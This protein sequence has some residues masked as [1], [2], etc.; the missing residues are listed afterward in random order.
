MPFARCL[1]AALADQ[2]LT[3]EEHDH[4]Q[5]VHD[6]H[7]TDY[8]RHMPAQEAAAQAARETFAFIE[9]DAAERRRQTFLS[10][11][12]RA[13]IQE[14]LDGH[15]N[16]M[17][18]KADPY[19][20]AQGL[21]D[22]L[23]PGRKG[24][25]VEQ[26]HEFWRGQAQGHLDGAYTTWKRNMLGQR[27]NL[28]GMA[29]VVRE[30][31]GERTGDEAAMM[32]AAG[33]KKASE[34]LRQA[35]NRFGGHIGHLEDWGLPQNHVADRIR[36]A[37]FEAWHDAMVPLL[38]RSRMVDRGMGRP[39]SDKMLKKAL[40]KTY[41]SILT[42]GWDTRDPTSSRGKAL[43]NK[44]DE[45]RFLHF[46]DADS[47]F[48]YQQK[49]G[50]GD[51]INAMLS[52]IDAMSRDVAHMQVMGPNPTATLA[53]LQQ[54]LVKRAAIDNEPARATKA[55]VNLNKLFVNYT[56]SNAAP[57]RP[58][59]A[60]AIDDIS[61]LLTAAQLGAAT[62]SAVPSDL[63]FQRLTRSFNGLPEIK[64][65]AT[66]LKQMNPAD[67][68]HRLAA[69][70]M[71]L[72]AQHYAQV[73]GQQGRYLG[74]IYGHEWSRWITDRVLGVSGLT[75]WTSAGR[76]AFGVDFYGHVADMRDVQ[77][78]ALRV[79][80]RQMLERYG[81]KQHDWNLIRSTE[82]MDVHGA[83]FISPPDILSRVDLAPDEA[84]DLASKLA[85]AAQT[86]TEFAVPSGSL[87]S[88][89]EIT[90]LDHPGEFVS[91]FKRSAAMYRTFGSTLLLSHGRRMMSLGKQPV[92]AGKYAASAI[93]SSVVAGAIA[94]QMK[95]LIAGRDP[96][97]M[98]GAAFWA[99]AFVTGGGG[100]LMADLVYAGINGQSS[101]GQGVASMVGGPIG[102][103]FGD[104]ANTFLGPGGIGAVG[105]EPGAT[106]KNMPTRALEFARRYMPGGSLWYA[107][108]LM[109][110]EMWDQLQ[111]MVDPGWQARS[112][113]IERWYS[114]NFH[115]QNWW[116]RGE[117]SPER[118]PD[119][120]NAGGQ[121]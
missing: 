51:P 86:E 13:H 6:M 88:R 33:W 120:S 3:Q 62:V 32:L 100:G 37:G 115:T 114:K 109:E 54:S 60:H 77:F 79:E 92:Q 42:G 16:L 58:R 82:A 98:E 25:A 87:Q 84:L 113:R 74:E 12:A 17:T 50:E 35:F 71:G 18:G 80:F 90:G 108:L 46:K 22:R 64:G 38:D 11:A 26:Q 101:A 43:A 52:H 8:Q 40:R 104:I 93:I 61:N 91:I 110:R 99:A 30:A 23:V 44:R 65:L 10:L 5:E 83:K 81:I 53:W 48:A 117:T 15:V 107:R 119:L 111:S 31:F 95:E 85:D 4:F 7:L 1:A 14:R 70:K 19:Q 28:P 36:E 29:N 96:R 116:H 39:L 78:S 105:N 24:F 47:W 45:S 9:G 112:A 118:A 55:N 49:Y 103:L 63:G 72:G 121:E 20:A 57:V 75:S 34:Q 68:A 2:L 69:I 97:P 89:A 106:A 94:I 66:I 41:N 56:R 27:R 59:L 76:A 21:Y 73:L 102:G 67:P